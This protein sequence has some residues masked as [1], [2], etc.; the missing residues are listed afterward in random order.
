[1]NRLIQF[2]QTFQVSTK[3]SMHPYPTAS[4]SRRE[5]LLKEINFWVGFQAQHP[6]IR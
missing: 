2:N 1:M 6:N 4:W 5:F 3:L